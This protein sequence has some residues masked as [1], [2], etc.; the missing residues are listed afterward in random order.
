MEA[1]DARYDPLLYLCNIYFT[2]FL[3]FILILSSI[4]FCEIDLI[5]YIMTYNSAASKP[6]EKGKH[7]T[8]EEALL[9]LDQVS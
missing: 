2:N 9:Y 7:L 6:A 5:S 3:L 4:C 8:V 1:E